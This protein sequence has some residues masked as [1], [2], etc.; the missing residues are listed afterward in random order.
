[1]SNAYVLTEAERELLDTARRVL[2]TNLSGFL[3]SGLSEPHHPRRLYT[4]RS[5]RAHGPGLTHHL[6]IISDTEGGL[7]GG[8][9][10]L[11]MAALLHLL[12]MGG[13]GRD[14]VVFHDEELLERL[15]WPDTREARVTIEGAVER[16][17]RPPTAGLA[18][19]R[20]GLGAESG[21]LPKC[22]S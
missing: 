12:W 4:L 8:R 20:W 22:R 19:S 17:T 18:P 6:E 16:S 1:M 9:E 2:G 7:P 14:E 3:L 11:V 21:A 5:I 13:E 10:P 15:S